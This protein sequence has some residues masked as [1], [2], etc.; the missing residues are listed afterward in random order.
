MSFDFKV[1]N[2]VWERWSEVEIDS[3]SVLQRIVVRD[4]LGGTFVSRG[5][6][7]EVLA[8]KQAKENRVLRW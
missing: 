3:M 7:R 1:K 6:M 4:R 8:T 2:E 5:G